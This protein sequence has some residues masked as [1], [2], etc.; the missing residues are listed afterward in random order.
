MK[1]SIDTVDLPQVRM[2][3]E[4]PKT[5]EEALERAFKSKMSGA[6]MVVGDP[7]PHIQP[8]N[9]GE[10]ARVSVTEGIKLLTEKL[11][12]SAS[13]IGR[14]LTDATDILVGLL[15]PSFMTE[16]V[17]ENRIY[18]GDLEKLEYWVNYVGEREQ[19]LGQIVKAMG[20]SPLIGS[21]EAAHAQGQKIG[22]E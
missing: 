18:G 14:H 17:Q 3:V 11:E 19:I 8:F 20:K 7:A 21:L 2:S 16:F 1:R 22:S 13:K 4:P 10:K 15:G 9:E 12:G 6:K 5:M